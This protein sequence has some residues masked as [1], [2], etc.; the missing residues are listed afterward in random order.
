[1]STSTDG[2]AL[3]VA[4]HLISRRDRHGNEGNVQ[5]DVEALLRAMSPGTIESQYRVGVGL[6]DLYLPN[7]RTF[8]E[9]KAYPTAA[10]PAKPRRGGESAA[11]QLE[12][13]VTTETAQGRHRTAPP[14]PTNG[15]SRD[16]RPDDARRRRWP[17]NSLVA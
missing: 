10:D 8:V 6:A 7:R 1:M 12:R 17:K 16:A 4:Q 5:A 14:C 3:V 2:G 15:W 13:Y 11:Q 9:V